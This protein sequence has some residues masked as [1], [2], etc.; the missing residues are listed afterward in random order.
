MKVMKQV[1]PGKN[2]PVWYVSN[3]AGYDVEGSDSGNPPVPVLQTE[4]ACILR[5]RFSLEERWMIVT[6]RSREGLNRADPKL[7]SPAAFKFSTAGWF[8]RLSQLPKYEIPRFLLT[9]DV[10]QV[11][12]EE[13]SRL[14]PVKLTAIC[15]VRK[16]SPRVPSTVVMSGKDMVPETG[17]AEV[18]FVQV[19]DGK[20]T[21]AGQ[22]GTF[23]TDNAALAAYGSYLRE[24]NKGKWTQAA[25]WRKQQAATQPDPYPTPLI[26]PDCEVPLVFF[27][28]DLNCPKCKSSFA[29]KGSFGGIVERIVPFVQKAEAAGFT[30]EQA[31]FLRRELERT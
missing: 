4:G 8:I 30:A 26:C 10:W 7:N 2:L 3:S 20:Y 14:V 12:R 22:P 27:G 28:D 31:E 21:V 24:K 16:F 6:V 23:E 11:S 13:D 17:E 29:H 19:I 15:P 25:D 18:A 1:V 9:G 5:A